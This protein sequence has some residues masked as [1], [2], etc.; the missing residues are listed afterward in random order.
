MPPP[1]A[2]PFGSLVASFARHLRARNLA[3]KTVDIYTGAATAFARWLTAE[4]ITRWPEVRRAELEQYVGDLARKRSGGYASNQYRA[5]QQFFKWLFTEEEIARNPMVG[6]KPPMVPEVPVAVVTTE[7]LVALFKSVDGRDLVSRRDAAILSLF[8]D[9][10]LRLAELAALTVG[11]LDLDGREVVVLGKGRRPRTVRFGRKTAVALDRYLRSR[12]AEKWSE[13][14]EL[15]LAEKGR[16]PLTRA[17]VYQMVVRRGEQA[18]IPGGLHPHQLRHT[19]AHLWLSEG[20]AEGDLMALAGW[21]SR[22]MVQRYAA[23]TASERARDAHD[24]LGIR[25]RL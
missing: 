9:T 19:F 7:K 24:R 5:L 1:L 2:S 4:G 3:P 10:G 17:G 6:M 11:D 18:G 12:G 25:D 23:S 13:R 14:P 21:R 22:Q 15:W 8:V 16:G 20:G